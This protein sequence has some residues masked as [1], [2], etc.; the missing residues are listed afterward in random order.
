MLVSGVVVLEFF[1]WFRVSQGSTD[2]FL[3]RGVII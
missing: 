1:N 2:L 3:R